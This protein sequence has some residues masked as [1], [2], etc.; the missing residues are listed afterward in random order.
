[1]LFNAF[2][3]LLFYLKAIKWNWKIVN[4]ISYMVY[5][6]FCSFIFITIDWVLSKILCTTF[7]PIA[8]SINKDRT[9]AL[10][11]HT[12]FI[13]LPMLFDLTSDHELRPHLH[14]S[15]H[16]FTYQIQNFNSC[17]VIRAPFFKSYHFAYVLYWC[18]YVYFQF[19]IFFHLLQFRFFMI[20][21]HSFKVFHSFLFL[22][23]MSMCEI[24]W[25]WIWKIVFAY[26][27]IFEFAC[28]LN[29]FI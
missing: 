7:F 27:Y 9:N 8:N 14:Y 26:T 10:F 2:A 1:M 22:T 28:V 19:N 4:C 17:L 20:M 5:F 18:M 6:S 11:S 12:L 15:N 25:A 16:S 24:F 29:P 3:T 13:T 21:S 23:L